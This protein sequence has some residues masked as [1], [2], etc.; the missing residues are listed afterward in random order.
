MPHLLFSLIVTGILIPLLAPFVRPYMPAFRSASYITMHFDSDTCTTAQTIKV[1]HAIHDV[2][3]IT[4]QALK[5]LDLIEPFLGDT[6]RL[7][8]RMREKGPQ[9]ENYRRL[10]YTY[11]MLFGIIDGRTSRSV[12]KARFD[13]VTALA[14]T[15]GVCLTDIHLSPQIRHVYS[16]FSNIRNLDLP[17]Y[18]NDDPLLAAPHYGCQQAHDGAGRY[19][20][21]YIQQRHI[22]LD[23]LRIFKDEIIVIC[24]SWFTTVSNTSLPTILT[25]TFPV[26]HTTLDA[27]P[28]PTNPPLIRHLDDI[29]T[30][31]PAFA[32]LH[33]LT[34]TRAV[35]GPH[36]AAT[37]E[38]GEDGGLAYGWDKAMML[39]SRR[40]ESA[41]RNADSLAL[42]AV[43]VALRGNDWSMGRARPAEVPAEWEVE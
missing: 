33:E 1:D 3:A 42:F 28:P 18:C 24:P 27:H 38:R 25:T 9:G 29:R 11:E 16:T 13:K 20:A 41:L 5:D 36:N 10:I 23:V 39:G 40:P 8:A 15:S 17:I 30:I 35:M 26:P 12:L 37:D 31:L 34:H 4:R 32:L 2:Q 6:N 19:V 14:Q 7:D 21:A 22:D 43:S